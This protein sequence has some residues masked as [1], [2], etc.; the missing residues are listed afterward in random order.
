M[1]SAPPSELADALPRIQQRFAHTIGLITS[2]GG[3]TP[4][5]VMA[6][7]WTVVVSWDPIMIM[8]V[9]GQD[10][11]TNELIQASGEFGVSI[12]ADTQGHLASRAGNVSGR[13]YFK[14]TDPEFQDLVHPARHIRAPLIRDAVL[15]AECIVEQK[16]D[17][18]GS[19]TGFIGRVVAGQIN[20]GVKPLVYHQ[21]KFFRLGGQITRRNGASRRTKRKVELQAS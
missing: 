19:Y 18:N 21:G 1:A 9:I 14:L 10:D 11:L 5:N 3:D 12:C 20:E 13:D 15:S 6:C 4:P 17:I 8:V 16:V 2:G 7:E